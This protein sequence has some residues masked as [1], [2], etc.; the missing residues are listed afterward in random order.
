MTYEVTRA[1]AHREHGDIGRVTL[2]VNDKGQF[3]L[4]GKT[5]PDASAEYLMTFALQCLQ[6]AYAGAKDNAE[7]VGAFEGRRDK[8]IAG[9]MGVRAGGSATT[10]RDKVARIIVGDWF[11]NVFAKDNP[12][13]EKVKAYSDANSQADKYAILDAIWADNEEVFGPAVDE[14]I[15]RRKAKA[16]AAKSIKVEL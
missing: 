16:Q 5:L 7:C 14:E 2:T 9:T 12:G 1:Y 3:A 8:I 6:D 10:E 4:D 15:E 11:R 13:H